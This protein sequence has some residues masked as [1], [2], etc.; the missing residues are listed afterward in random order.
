M[1]QGVQQHEN[2]VSQ[3]APSHDCCLSLNKEVSWRP[4]E[5]IQKLPVKCSGMCLQTQLLGRIAS[6]RS[7]W[8][9]SWSPFLLVFKRGEKGGR[10]WYYGIVWTCPE[11]VKL[12]VPSQYCKKEERKARRKKTKHKTVG[13]LKAI[14]VT[15]RASGFVYKT[16]M[17]R[18][19]WVTWL[20]KSLQR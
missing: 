17:S 9:I 4:F 15:A 14:L 11:S 7:A 5:L 13:L 20:C 19:F 12:W 6:F 8:V 3:I 10:F 2:D 18:A 1:V 16:V